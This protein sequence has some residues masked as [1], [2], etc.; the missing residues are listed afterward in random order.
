MSVRVRVPLRV[1]I[2]KIYR[3]LIYG[4]RSILDP[5]REDEYWIKGSR[6]ISHYF[7]NTY[8]LTLPQVWNIV[9][10]YE[11]DKVHHCQVCGKEL[12]FQRLSRGFGKTCD[13]R[14]C[15]T[16]LI[17]TNDLIRSARCNSLNSVRSQAL[18]RC[19]QFRNQG[20]PC[21]ECTLYYATASDHIKFGITSKELSDRDS[22]N[23]SQYSSINP[24]ITGT[25][26]RI[27]LIESEVKIRLNQ[28]HE[29]VHIDDLDRLIN[30]VNQIDKELGDK[31]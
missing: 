8:G 17:M 5:F 7:L 27:S 19:T 4:V 11:K 13:S 21:D 12:R 9:T 30:L 24:I 23:H 14:S 15:K 26:D 29:K 31:E 1:L 10:G 18:G 28:N 2:M 16:K 6:G 22:W 25:R 20:L 3:G